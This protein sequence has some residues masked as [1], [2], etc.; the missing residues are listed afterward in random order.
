MGL[1]DSVYSDQELNFRAK[2]VLL[3]L[4][5]RTNQ[6]GESWYVTVTIR[7]NTSYFPSKRQQKN[8]QNQTK[9]KMLYIVLTKVL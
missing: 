6:N 2:T 7:Q 8:C 9:N 5:D 4:H 1:F 3:Y